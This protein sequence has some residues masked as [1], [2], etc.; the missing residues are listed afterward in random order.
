[1]NNTY[2]ITQKKLE[3]LENE[4]EAIKKSLREESIG[5]VPSFLESGDPNPDFSVFE[6]NMLDLNSRFEVLENILKNYKII[7]T[8]PKNDRDKIQLGANVVFKD[9]AAQAEY[10]IVGT[11]EAN[12]FEG[13]ISNESP[14]G[15]AFLGKKVGDIVNVPA[16]HKNY[17]ILKIQYGDA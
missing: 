9:D 7:E 16:S 15:M 3:E 8:P 4:Y 6:E 5:E 10:K 2:Y 14:V 13:K 12:P 11:I 1:M 17:K